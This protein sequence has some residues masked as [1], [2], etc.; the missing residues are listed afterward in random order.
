MQILYLGNKHNLAIKNFFKFCLKFL[1]LFEL[2]F[3]S[4][5]H[6][7]AGSQVSPMDV[8]A[9]SQTSTLHD[10]EESRISSPDFAAR[11]QIFLLYFLAGRFDKKN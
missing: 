6:Y 8:A 2:E 11:S 7:A 9:E 5:L 1:E 3:D 10:A 4:L